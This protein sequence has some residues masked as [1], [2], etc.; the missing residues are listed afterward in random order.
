MVFKQPPP[1]PAGPTGPQGPKGD[2]GDTGTTGAAG[3]NAAMLVVNTLADVPA[4]T[5]ADTLIVTRT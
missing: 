3:A 5:A 2:K 4:G 1:G